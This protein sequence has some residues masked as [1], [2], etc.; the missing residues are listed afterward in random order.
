MTDTHF[1]GFRKSYRWLF[2]LPSLSI[3]I[4]YTGA[5]LTVDVVVALLRGYA[6]RDVVSALTVG[7]LPYVISHLFDRKVLTAKRSLGFY[8]IFLVF[9]LP[10][11]LLQKQLPLATLPTVLLSFLVFV[12]IARRVA[13]AAYLVSY[14]SVLWILQSAFLP[15]ALTVIVIYLFVAAPMLYIINRRVKIAAG[16]GGLRYLRGFLRYTLSGEKEEVEQCLKAATVRKTIPMHVFEVYSDGQITGRVVV[17]GVHPGPVR[18][19]GSS[20]LPESILTRCYST[21]FLKAPAGHGENMAVSG[22]VGSLVEKICSSETVGEEADSAAI[23]FA[24]GKLVNSLAIK[25]SNGISL[26]LLDPQV[27]MEDLP[28]Y[29]REEFEKMGV[30]LA[31]LHNMIDNEYIQLPESQSENPE[32][33]LEVERTIMESLNSEVSRGGLKTGLARVDYTD[34]AS[35][36]RGGIS[37]LVLEVENRR[38]GIISVDG[39]NM[40]PTFKA[41]VHREVGGLVDYLLLGTTDTHVMTGLFQGVDYYPVGSLNSELVLVNIQQ[42]LQKALET[43]RES[44]VKYRVVPVNTLFMD[45]SRLKSLSVATKYNVRDGLLL[46]VIAFLSWVP[47]LIL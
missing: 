16:V 12:A 26:C 15:T 6:P 11:L 28:A 46:A 19:L 36:G 44:H 21:V 39:N 9:L 1:E 13:L 32:L 17:S 47:L 43:L 45:G 18:T 41:Q 14:F 23:G 7:G 37:C 38:V 29:L 34:G 8:A 27:P 35:V 33:Y 4:V 5:L 31:D 25:M 2:R 20:T 30:V 42:C 40:D 24:E 10:V 22:E 3:M